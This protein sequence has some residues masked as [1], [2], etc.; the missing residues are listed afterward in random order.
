MGQPGE[1]RW[2]EANPAAVAN[3][4]KD[5]GIVVDPAAVAVLQRDDR[6]ACALS[7]D[8]MAWFPLNEA[9]LARLDREARVL[10]LLTQHCNFRVP[11]VDYEA[12]TGWQVRRSVPGHCDPVATYRRATGDRAFATAL[13]HA[14]GAM[15]ASQHHAIDTADLT[16]WL[17]AKPSWPPPKSG[18][19]RDLP[20]V[21][22]D[23]PLID[24]ALQVIDRHESELDTADPVLIHSDLGFHNMVVDQVTGS[25]VGVFD[26]D[27]AA[28]ADRHHDFKYLLLDVADEV[29]L[30]SAIAAYRAAGGKSIDLGRVR[31]LNAA[32]AVGFLALRAGHGPNERPAGR[33]L[34]EDLNWTRLALRRAEDVA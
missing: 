4:L 34:E 30:Q 23:A 31:L 6:F 33:S 26:Y 11:I 8:R 7:G 5:A 9:G 14:I 20:L 3:A 21:V 28:F 27:D 32:S 19:E 2:I 10:R 15:L 17:P 25:L 22:H 18:I 13:G 29:L 16:G 1:H 12:P 24:R